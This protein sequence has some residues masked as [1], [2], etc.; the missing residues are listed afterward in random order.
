MYSKFSVL[1]T[2]RPRA[3]NVFINCLHRCNTCACRIEAL[4]HGRRALVDLFD[5]RLVSLWMLSPAPS[6]R[7]PLSYLTTTFWSESEQP[8]PM[9]QATKSSRWRLPRVIVKGSCSDSC[10]ESIWARISSAC[11]CLSAST[12]SHGTQESQLNFSLI[13]ALEQASVNETHRIISMES[14]Q[15]AIDTNRNVSLIHFKTDSM[16]NRA[17]RSRRDARWHFACLP[18]ALIPAQQLHCNDFGQHSLTK[19]A[20]W[21]N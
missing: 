17:S 10:L 19:V 9:A 16:N 15:S 8:S 5:S 18:L 2:A 1:I 6:S 21:E 14:S 11:S 13:S 4:I 7:G 3:P 20:A 12:K